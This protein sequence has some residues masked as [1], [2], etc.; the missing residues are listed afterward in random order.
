[1]TIT[2]IIPFSEASDDVLET[3]EINKNSH[4][5]GSKTDYFVK[6]LSTEHEDE[7]DGVFARTRDGGWFGL[8]FWWNSGRLDIDGTLS[9][10]LKE[11]I[12]WKK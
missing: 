8:G 1:M 12:E 11:Q 9:E 4:V 10:S 3:W 7:S 6:F 2:E 5:F